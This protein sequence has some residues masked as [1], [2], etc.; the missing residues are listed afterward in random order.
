ML[1]DMN[2]RKRLSSLLSV[3]TLTLIAI[4]TL[5]TGSASCGSDQACFYFTQVEYDISNSCPSPE[6]ALS[7]FRGNFCSTP[8]TS[9]DSD[10]TFDGTT[11]CYDVTE[12][13]DF[14]DCGIGPI[15]PPEPGVV[16]SVGSSGVAGS[17]GVGGAG[18]AGGSGAGG[19]N[20]CSTCAE[21][22]TN[23][24]PDPLCDMS[25]PIYE[26]YSECKCNGPCGTV[27]QDNCI[28]GTTS[29]EC[30]TC[31]IDMANGCGNQQQACLND[32]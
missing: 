2:L 16:T 18:G 4:A 20:G 17:G 11:C 24:N 14:F 32:N 28:N 25:L 23:T 3:S 21:F 26:S 10:G 8:I 27:C 15:P 13:D 9:V 5:S 29:M 31:L 6:E 12:S 22:L 7:F 19:N 30:E 1:E